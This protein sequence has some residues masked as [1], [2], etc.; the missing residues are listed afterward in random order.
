MEKARAK[1]LGLLAR[2]EK[3]RRGL[4]LSL[5][6]GGASSRVADAVLTE[7]EAKGLVDDLRFCRLYLSHHARLRPRSRRLLLR[8]L[9]REGCDPKTIGR[10]MEEMS[11]ELDETALAEAAAR[12][13]LRASGGDPDRLRRYLSRRGFRRGLIEEV[14]RAVGVR[15]DRPD[16]R[17]G[18]N[19]NV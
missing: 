2:R 19:G 18:E 5:L 14:L 11:S 6:R 4:R 10:A 15:T 9:R 12:K 3:S 1:A 13:R 7:L 17:G 16:S 8:E